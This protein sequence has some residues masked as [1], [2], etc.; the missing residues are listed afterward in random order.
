MNSK[1]W[2]V[3]FL[4]FTIVPLS[5]VASWVVKVDPFFHYHMPYTQTY[6]YELY[7]QRSQNNGISRN[8]DYEGLITGTSMVENFKTTDVEKVFGY[9][10]VKVP[11]SG[12]T[13]KEINDNIKLALDHNQELKVVIRGL[14]MMKFIEEKDAMRFDLG[15][16]PTYLYNENP[17]DDVKYVFNRDIIFKTVYGMVTANN[18]EGF[19][20]GITSFDSYSNW[21][22]RFTFGVNAVFPEGITVTKHSIEQVDISEEEK[23]S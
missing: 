15:E 23:K 19:T 5:I 11:Y 7:N 22:E 9:K 13:Y 18:E 2:I 21:M 8:F 17:L 10:F 16:Y 6:F 14:D 1:L 3:G 12:G 20:P 4:S